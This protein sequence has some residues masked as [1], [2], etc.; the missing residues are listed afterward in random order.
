MGNTPESDSAFQELRVRVREDTG[1]KR[2]TEDSRRES[3]SVTPVSPAAEIGLH[4]GGEAVPWRSPGPGR[5]RMGR[6]IW[7]TFRKQGSATGCC[8]RAECWAGGPIQG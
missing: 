7:E 4:P 3:G 6:G 8:G 5:L 2:H 1:R